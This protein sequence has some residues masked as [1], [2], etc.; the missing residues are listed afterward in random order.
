MRIQRNDGSGGRRHLPPRLPCQAADA[1]RS[2]RPPVRPEEEADEYD[3]EDDGDE[4]PRRRFPVGLV[5]VLVFAVLVAVGG[6][7]GMQLYGELAGSGDSVMGEA[8]TVEI[9]EGANASSIADQLEENGVIQNGWLFKL[10]ARYSGK[11]SNLQPARWNCAP[12]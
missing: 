2:P 3:A 12:A 7:K 8:V 4:R 10:Y 1:A 6:W 11:A 9:A 5:I